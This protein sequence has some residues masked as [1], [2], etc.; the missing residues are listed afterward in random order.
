MSYLRG[1]ELSVFDNLDNCYREAGVYIVLIIMLGI[2]SFTRWGLWKFI[3]FA[4][5]FYNL[6]FSSIGA[7]GC[8]LI[9][10]LPAFAR[11]EGSLRYWA[12]EEYFCI[13]FILF[14]SSRSRRGL[15]V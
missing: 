5:F 3:C 13:L 2:W 15:R 4:S 9:A 11:G 14:S 1:G 10:L 12:C 6:T 7:D 8:W